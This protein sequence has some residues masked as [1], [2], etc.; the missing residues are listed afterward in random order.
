MVQGRHL[1]L[2][3]TS[4]SFSSVTS[5]NLV[6]LRNAFYHSPNCAPSPVPCPNRAPSLVS[7]PREGTARLRRGL[8]E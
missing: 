4:F 2:L 8:R 5:S 3:V 6:C 7:S 1:M